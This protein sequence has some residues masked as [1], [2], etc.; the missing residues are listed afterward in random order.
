M[1]EQGGWPTMAGIG[2]NSGEPEV[3]I[4]PSVKFPILHKSQPETEEAEAFRLRRNAEI[5]HWQ[6]AKFTAVN[7]VTNERDFRAKVTATLFPTPVKGT[8]R[9]D[10]GGGYK[11]KLVHG[12]TYTLGDKDAVDDEGIKV[13]IHKQI[14]DLETVVAALGDAHRVLFEQ[15]VT[16]EPKISGSLFEKL[17]KENPIHVTVRDMISEHLTIKPGSPT[18]DFEEPKESKE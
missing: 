17:D 2:H 8:Q 9:Y 4:T 5:Q 14:E 6:Q 10:L 18:L 15:L 1:T 12:L 16:W 3:E 7:A 11:I 13:P